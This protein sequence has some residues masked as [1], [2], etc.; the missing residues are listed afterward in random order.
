MIFEEVYRSEQAVSEDEI[1]VANTL[2]DNTTRETG[3]GLLAVFC[4]GFQGNQYDLRYFRN[5]IGIGYPRARLLCCSSVEDNTHRPIEEQGSLIAEE[6]SRYISGMDDPSTVRRIVFVGHSL[7]TLAIRAAISM[8]CME[9]YIDRLQSFISLG[10]TH[11]GYTFGNNNILSSAMWIYQRWTKSASL[12][13]LNLKDSGSDPKKGYVH[14][15]AQRPVG[16]SAFKHVVLVAS[17]Q[18]RYAP[19]FSARIQTAPSADEGEK[20]GSASISMVR[21][22]LGPVIEQGG[23]TVTRLGICFGNNGTA[24]LDS[25]IGRAAHIQFLEVRSFRLSCVVYLL[26]CVVL[27]PSHQCVRFCSRRIT[28]SSTT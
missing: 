5:R 2:G 8:P 12:S 1:S 15:L 21:G 22:L 4:H 3:D 9:P 26:L 28:G 7:G 13:Q 27:K 18:D 16:L 17:G 11:L 20:I 25:A 6:V 23:T 14:S 24:F 10:G 19:F